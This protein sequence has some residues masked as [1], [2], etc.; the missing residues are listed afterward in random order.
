MRNLKRALSLAL[1]AIML[2]GMMVMGASAAGIDDFTDSDAVQNVEAVTLTS[3][4]GIFQ[5]RTDGSFDPTAP[6]T[7]A[8]MAVII[9]KIL[10][11]A[12][13]S[14][15]NFTGTQ[16][17]TDVPAWAEGY[18][19]MASAL[20]IIAGRGNGIF[21][22][23]T[24]VTTV[25]AATM[26]LKA[27]GYYVTANDQLGADWDLEVTSR[28]NML[29]LYGDLTLNMR[30]PLTR[31]NVA[32]LVYNT[33]FA[34]M[35]AFN[36]YRGQYVKN[37][38]RDVV[39]TAG[40]EDDLNTLARNTFGLYAVEGIVIAN[41][42]TDKSYMAD[43]RAEART[44][45]LFEEDTDLNH[46]GRNEVKEGDTYDFE[47]GTGLD[48]IG[49]NAKI[50]Y[51]M[52]RNTPVVYTIFDKATLVA[53]ISYNS[54]TT[55]LA[56]AANEAGFQ[57]DSILDLGVPQDKNQDYIVNYDWDVR[58]K[59]ITGVYD[60]TLT[61]GV[62]EDMVEGLDTLIVI[63]N[64]ANKQVDYVIA[65][66]Q[67]LDTVKSVDEI[68]S[69]VSYEM[70]LDDADENLVTEELEEGQYAIVTDI[71]N[72][73]KI[74]VIEP[75]VMLS[76]DLSR[77][78]GK[79]T[80]GADQVNTKK[81]VVDG[82]TYSESPVWGG[83]EDVTY[84]EDYICMAD[85]ED[86]GDVTLV[87]DK[88][89]KVIGQAE[90]T[91]ETNYAYVAQFGLRHSTTGLNTNERILTALIY[92]ADGTNEVYEVNLDK[93]YSQFKTMVKDTRTYATENLL[94]D[95]LNGTGLKLQQ[96][97]GAYKGLYNV[98]ISGGKAIIT[99]PTG[100]YRANDSANSDNHTDSVAP[101]STTVNPS[102]GTALEDEGSTLVKSHSTVVDDGGWNVKNWEDTTNAYTLMNNNDTVYFYVTGSYNDL[103]DG[104]S[105]DTL[106]VR[107][108]TGI[109]NVVKV[110]NK[111]TSDSTINPAVTNRPNEGMREALYKHIKTSGVTGVNQRGAVGAM[112][113]QGVTIDGSDVYY[114]NQGDYEVYRVDGGYAVQY[115]VY[116][117]KTGEAQTVVYQD[118]NK[119]FETSADARKHAADKPHGF[120]VLGAKDLKGYA[121]N[122]RD[123]GST[124][125]DI[126]HYYGYKHAGDD[127][128]Y[129]VRDTAMYDEYVDNLFTQEVPV[130]TITGDV[131]VVDV[132]NT[133]LNTVNKI[134]RA[135]REDTA[136]YTGQVRLSYSYDKNYDTKVLFV[137]DYDPDQIIPEHPVA[138]DYNFSNN[139]SVYADGKDVKVYGYVFKGNDALENTD[140][141][142][143][144]F[145]NALDGTTAA[146]T[147]NVTYDV[148]AIPIGGGNTRT[149]QFTDS[150]RGLNLRDVKLAVAPDGTHIIFSADSIPG[151]TVNQSVY[152]YEVTVTVTFKDDN[153][154]TCTL[155][156]SNVVG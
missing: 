65:L 140:A 63:S 56:D 47:F 2:L 72:Q 19:N 147:I 53:T 117:N 41:G 34:Q 74:K 104:S 116:S 131:I 14:P 83:A 15:D 49:H 22:P 113:I 8:E 119:P 133:G 75:A 137:T 59:D 85:I 77:I 88:D 6:V 143:T 69:K 124:L 141:D 13:V 54:N 144:D 118:D 68:R 82:T 127:S 120:Y 62:G 50:Y 86:I 20:N 128:Y 101:A 35:V 51:K 67:Y 7:R 94:R 99:L 21:D 57:K 146:K 93:S 96:A 46:D 129:V 108:I 87:M 44:L 110:E 89:G 80:G 66:D 39:V 79:S 122:P 91:A 78:I 111:A 107:V 27:L 155:S 84:L 64:S 114:Y 3:S 151:L 52:D 132:G 17:F 97:D 28:A 103:V 40:T 135:L 11:G 31:D 130:G 10:H 149:Y 61:Y 4:L 145:M 102:S 70:T 43:T 23:N 25:E 81:V 33:L 123:D 125:V 9:C 138:A 45:V 48:M 95:A 1:A 150:N 26:L 106:N 98:E 37:T 60:G 30:T 29:G 105:K 154:R 142:W 76:G 73:G 112:L 32:E 58:Y 109:K 139:L 42:Y 71:G 126:A 115:T 55:K 38:N 136:G 153:G 92:F 16:K 121:G 5:G 148:V 156:G 100:V 12:D 134:V 36:D 90:K 152:G 24:T 18:V